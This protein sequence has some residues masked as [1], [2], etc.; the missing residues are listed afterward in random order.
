MACRFWDIHCQKC[1]DLEI[2]NPDQKSLKVI[3][4]DTI[5]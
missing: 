5:R 1:R 2:Q 4:S 3:E